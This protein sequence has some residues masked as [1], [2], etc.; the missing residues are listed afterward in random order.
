MLI[1]IDEY[2]SKPNELPGSKG[3]NRKAKQPKSFVQYLNVAN[4]KRTM[5]KANNIPE[6]NGINTFLF[7]IIFIVSINISLV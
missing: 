2:P 7:L 6:I 5:N 3:I 4:Q 1:T